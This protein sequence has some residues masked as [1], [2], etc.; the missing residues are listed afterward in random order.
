MNITLVTAEGT[1]LWKIVSESFQVGAFIYW[2]SGPDG[3]PLLVISHRKDV[4]VSSHSELLEATR[5]H[6]ENV[7]ATEPDA[8]GRSTEDGYITDWVSVG[9]KIVTPKNLR[10][11]IC[12]AL[13]LEDLW[14]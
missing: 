6:I 3:E 1:I 4:Q 11:I 12:K 2:K 10:P 9:F 7:P 13:E 8:A 5:E 14:T